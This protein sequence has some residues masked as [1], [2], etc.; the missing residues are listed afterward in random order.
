MPHTNT[1]GVSNVDPVEEG[2]VVQRADGNTSVVND[3]EPIEEK[4]EK[5]EESR[6]SERKAPTSS[7]TRKARGERS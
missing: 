7:A 5:K 2:T 1:S 4:T 3:M 6:A